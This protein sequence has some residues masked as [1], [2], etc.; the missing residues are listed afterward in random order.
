M[1]QRLLKQ[2]NELNPKIMEK[3]S[4]FKTADYSLRNNTSLKIDNLKKLFIMEQ[5]N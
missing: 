3:I 5:N 1:Q 4:T 2:K